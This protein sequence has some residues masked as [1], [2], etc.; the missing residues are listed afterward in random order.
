MGPIRPGDI[1][2]RQMPINIDEDSSSAEER[3]CNWNGTIMKR[4]LSKEEKTFSKPEAPGH[5]AQK[6]RGGRERCLICRRAA[7]LKG[8]K[9]LRCNLCPRSCHMGCLSSSGDNDAAAKSAQANFRWQC[10]KCHRKEAARLKRLQEQEDRMRR[11]Q[12]QQLAK[13]EEKEE[14]E[15]YRLEKREERERKKQEDREE[16]FRHRVEERE[17]RRKERMMAKRRNWQYPVEDL[18][19]QDEEEANEAASGIEGAPCLASVKQQCPKP[20]PV[21]RLLIASAFGPGKLTPWLFGTMLEVWDFCQGVGKKLKCPQPGLVQFMTAVS[22]SSRSHILGDLYVSLLRALLDI[23]AG[24]NPGGREGAGVSEETLARWARL[25]DSTT[26]PELV[27]RYFIRGYNQLCKP[28]KQAVQKLGCVNYWELDCESH[29]ALLKCLCDDIL[30]ADRMKQFLESQMEAAIVL[31]KGKRAEEMEERRIKNEKNRQKDAATTPA[32]LIPLSE[33]P[34]AP[35]EREDDL[36]AFFA[37]KYCAVKDDQSMEIDGTN[38]TQEEKA[39]EKRKNLPKASERKTRVGQADSQSSQEGAINA[40]QGSFGQTEGSWDLTEDVLKRV[41]HGSLIAFRGYCN[42][43]RPIFAYALGLS[44]FVGATVEEHVAAHI[45]LNEYGDRV[46]L[47]E[48]SARMGRPI[49]SCIKVL[50]TPG[51]KMSALSKLKIVTAIA[52]IDD[53][54]Y[55]EKTDTY[56]IVNTP[57]VFSTC[58][59]VVKNLLQERTRHKVKVLHGNGHDELLKVMDESC[60]PPF[61]TRRSSHV[62]DPCY[63]L[64]DPF[65]QAMQKFVHLRSDEAKSISGCSAEVVKAEGADEGAL[66]YWYLEDE[67]GATAL[68]EKRREKDLRA[69]EREERLA[70]WRTRMATMAAVNGS[71]E[72]AA[73]A[74][75]NVAEAEQ[76]P[77]F[78]VPEHIREFKGD[79]SDRRAVLA[80]KEMVRREEERLQRLK[81]DYMKRKEKELRA[82]KRAR[83]EEQRKAEEAVK[84][85]EEREK[86]RDEAFEREMCKLILRAQPLGKDRY[87]NRYWWFPAESCVLFVEESLK[88]LGVPDENGGGYVDADGQLQQQQWWGYST[89]EELDALIKSLNPKGIRESALQASITHVYDKICQ[90]TEKKRLG[91]DGSQSLEEALDGTLEDGQKADGC[92]QEAMKM[93]TAIEGVLVTLQASPAYAVISDCLYRRAR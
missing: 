73:A 7:C 38:A 66:N 53:L 27:R 88:G 89:K 41:R 61:A 36:A 54:N 22:I 11:K 65:Y 29:L 86:K 45:Q 34:F 16:K 10:A 84:L 15:R 81:V 9:L 64:R 68:Q 71:Q 92:N 51:L 76:E 87:H 4:P 33:N 60:L 83:E 31:C 62:I 57:Y 20:R 48:A 50:D 52:S 69:A 8:S 39:K 30:D 24:Q 32:Q 26:W 25:L 37:E 56:Y 43:R 47:P 17:R 93:Q 55:P 78:E 19:L 67:A 75:E 77:T 74:I 5:Q 82:A 35:L 90:A 42:K 3:P 44:D 63:T 79:H 40:G 85:R 12:I 23:G 46:I 13:Q 59:K 58:W 6:E 49:V 21:E 18:E 14:R 80:H 72:G 2:S 28:V 70:A 1:G 91:V